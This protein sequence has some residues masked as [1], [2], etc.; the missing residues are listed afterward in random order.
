M[1]PP[2][3]WNPS[4]MLAFSWELC[5]LLQKLEWQPLNQGIPKSG[6]AV[7][8]AGVDKSEGKFGLGKMSTKC[9]RTV[10]AQETDATANNLGVAG[11][12]DISGGAWPDT[13]LTSYIL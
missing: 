1:G 9:P 3:F 6:E 4:T 12:E 7:Q 2:D 8:E 11:M 13:E 5:A 10:R